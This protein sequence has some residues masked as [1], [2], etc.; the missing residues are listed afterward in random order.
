M[1]HTTRPSPNDARADWHAKWIWHRKHLSRPWN[2]YAYFHRTVELPAEPRRAV[3]RISAESRYTLYVNGRRIHHGPARSFP[4]HQSFDTLD[5]TGA[6]DMGRNAICAV[7][8]QFGVPTFQSVYRDVS[9]FILDGEIDLGGGR[10]APLHTPDGWLCR[11]AKSWRADVVRKT[12]QI[13]FQEHFDA[14]ADPAEWMSADYDPKPEDGWRAPFVSGHV[15]NAPWFAMEERGVP[16]LADHVEE[17]SAVLAQFTGENARGYKVAQDVYH[18]PLHEQ[19]KRESNLVEDPAAML[20]N[21]SAVTTIKPPAAGNFVA[22][23]LDLGQYR[24]G[25]FML[26]VADAAG[27]EI[28]DL[29]YAEELD[30]KQQF[31]Q[32]VS[33]GSHCEEATADRYRCRPG[34]QRWETFGFVGMRYAAVVFRNVTR[35]LR[36]RHVALRQVHANLDDVGSFECSDERLNRVWRVAR[37]TQRNC[38]FDAYVDCPWREQAMWWGDARVQSRVTLHA[39]G[40]TSLLER[41]IRLV[42]RSQQGDGALH[43]HPPADIPGHRLPDFML[44]WVASLWDHQ[45]HTGK[46]EL[47][48]ECAPALHRLMEFFARHER[49]DGLV[50]GFE[51]WWVFLDWVDLYRA[52]FSAVLNL[53][54]LQGLRHAAALSRAID[55]ANNTARYEAK[56]KSLQQSIER[57]F[58]DESEN[59]WRDGFDVKH[60]KRIEQVSQHANALAIL[61]DLKREHHAHVAREHLLKPAQ[62]RK[63]KTLTGS[64]FF[65]AYILE[66]MLKT[67]LRR[68]SIEVI[69]EK[70]FDGM[71]ARGGATTFWE[72]WEPTVHSRCHAWSASPLYH[73]SEQV[74]GVMPA[75]PGWRKVRIAPMVEGLEFARGVVPSPA[76]LIHVDW[77]HAGDDQLAVRVEIPPGAEA[78]F[79]SP[80][81]ETRTLGPGAHEFQT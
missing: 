74:L 41:G 31:P 70:W 64:P 79:V 38:M 36:V 62:A 24:T 71:I 49:R 3:V 28:I 25:H 10:T 53:M 46:I 26:D 30:A 54:Y 33:E 42:A 22:L 9:G 29:I 15:G 39:F 78:E 60:D 44:T 7:V 21:D 17:F 52:D 32:L 56:A 66:A 37:E 4:S 34:A 58:W 27:D 11:P 47:A 50:G 55:D 81:G 69:R 77:E 8:H 72:V 35:P 2:S 13:G 12:I 23:T 63:P 19:R 61:L 73:L 68:E 76:G 59:V 6:L 20:R 57:H 48:R 80:A 40:D 14:D 75:A 65:Y 16:L 45:F 1:A 67:G 18:L 51:G 43:A 5:L